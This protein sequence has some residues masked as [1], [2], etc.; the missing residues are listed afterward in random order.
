M[1]IAAGV[2]RDGAMATAGTL[3]DMAAERG[4]AASLDSEHHLD[5]QPGEP[6]R[7]TVNESLPC[8][9]YDIGHLQQWPGHL[10]VQRRI[11]LGLRRG[12]YGKRIQWA[13]GGSKT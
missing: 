7:M 13:Y 2:V 11:F 8:G 3:I 12:R 4:G 1:P 6:T 9:A 5:V 10:A